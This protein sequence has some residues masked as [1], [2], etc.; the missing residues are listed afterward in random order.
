MQSQARPSWAATWLFLV[1][2]SA[3]AA[4]RALPRRAGPEGGPGSRKAALSGAEEMDRMWVRGWEEEIMRMRA[5]VS[6][7]TRKA[8]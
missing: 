4:W 1:R 3:D 8:I 7:G 6:F 5:A 2:A